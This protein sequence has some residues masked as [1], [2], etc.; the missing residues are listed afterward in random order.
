MAVRINA[1]SC[2]NALGTVF[3][4]ATVFFVCS[5]FISMRSVL[6]DPIAP[7]NAG[8]VSTGRQSPRSSSRTSNRTISRSTVSRA[9]TGATVAPSRS[10]AS[11]STVSRGTAGS[12]SVSSRSITPTRQNA[13]VVSRGV[14]ARGQ[15]TRTSAN[16]RAVRART[17]TNATRVAAIGNVTS[18]GDRASVNTS[19]SYLSSR[20][21]TGNYSNI[22]DSTT[23]LISAE[24]YS[25]CMDSYYAC[26]DEICTARSAA[27]GRCSCAGR[28]V[29]FL[30]AE[31]AL[32]SANEELITLSGQ[33][34]LLI[35][36]KGKGDEIAS[37]FTLTEAEQ[38]MNCVSWK[39]T[40]E[41][42]G[43]DSTEMKNWCK[44][45]SMEYNS[46]GSSTNTCS[47][48]PSY[49]T[50]NS[51][52]FNLDDL[53]N[54]GGSSSDIMA[55]LKAWADAKDLAKQ[56]ENDEENVLAKYNYSYSAVINAMGGQT[57]NILDMD[58]TGTTLDKLAKKWGYKLF[59]Y[60]H[61]NV[62]GRVLDSCFNGIY[63]ACGTPPSVTDSEGNKHQKCMNGATT[64][65]PFN[66]NSYI[67]VETTTN[68]SDA[69]Y[70]D[71][72]LNER[73]SG[74]ATASSSASC[75]GYSATTSSTGTRTTTSSSDP[76]YNLRGPVADARRSIMQKY[77]LDAN[78]ACDAYGESLK[79]TA[80]NINYQKVAAQQALQQ[81]RLEFKQQEDSETE[82]NYTTYASNF[83][84]C[85]D[86]IWECYNDTED[87]ETGWTSA[88]IK[89]YCAQK[90]NVPHCYEPM[91]CS[92]SRLALSAVIDKPDSAQCEFRQDFRKNTC[93]NVVTI[94]E[95]LYGANSQKTT[96]SGYSSLTYSD[97]TK[98][99]SAELR[100]SCLQEAG[101]EDV[102]SWG[103]DAEKTY[104]CTIAEV[105]KTDEFGLSGYKPEDKDYT[106]EGCPYITEC[107]S[108]YVL[109]TVGGT[110]KCT[111]ITPEPIVCTDEM[112]DGVESAK[113]SVIV[114]GSTYTLGTCKIEKCLS[115]YTMN[116]DG[117]ACVADRPNCD[118]FPANA[119]RGHR[120]WNADVLSGCIIDACQ[121]GY[122]V[123]YDTNECVESPT[124]CASETDHIASGTKNWNEEEQRWE[125]CKATQSSQ[126]ETNYS[127][128]TT[129]GTC[130]QTKVNC[131]STETTA[132]DGYA[133]TSEKTWN[134]TAYGPCK[135]TECKAHA[136]VNSDGG[137][138]C[139][140]GYNW[141]G[142]VCE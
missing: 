27:K 60:A 10:T 65:C 125:A 6:A 51:Y 122:G 133:A 48:R 111:L 8:V 73:G 68:S 86:E 36:T 3:L 59:E 34:S 78:S 26:M 21:Y 97:T 74:N 101:V 70:G 31:E 100:E 25:N 95:I 99:N 64:A 7:Q 107:I 75:F 92:P 112:G 20:L 131:T 71:V 120:E 87:S 35:A 110:K 104:R 80:Q 137:C 45:H 28:A 128:N 1:N 117:T 13:N 72:V 119:L 39:E 69:E 79:N 19:Y 62:C 94:S 90:S 109:T 103:K 49:C 93:R 50:S 12:R 127:V 54:I 47:D 58:D 32:E 135:V 129:N 17:A 52:G 115:H 88:R 106:T 91:V 142:S 23:G 67:R 41:Q 134:G 42:Y 61:N 15:A 44:E 5:T 124:A 138:A 98:I 118:E 96:Y 126:C 29:N 108:G 30:A 40:M 114:S 53:S 2:K 63:E 136:S 132:L 11:R 14:S 57:N 38:V 84:S 24:A 4:L 43:R 37:A 33:L 113:R 85:L 105:H 22:I 102:R 77:L 83:V 56:Y 76:Y 9:T 82:S 16:N 66:Y 116:T 81:K 89:T 139:N 121:G 130:V 140:A 46:D 18:G 55:Q 123:K 141:T